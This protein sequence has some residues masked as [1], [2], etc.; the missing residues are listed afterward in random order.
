[1][2]SLIENKFQDQDKLV[3][4]RLRAA[5]A[6]CPKMWRSWKRPVSFWAPGRQDWSYACA[7]GHAHARIVEHGGCAH[8]VPLPAGAHT[9]Q[10]H[11]LLAQGPLLLRSSHCHAAQ[12]YPVLSS[13]HCYDTGSEGS[14]ARLAYV[15]LPLNEHIPTTRF[16]RILKA[17]EQLPE[18]PPRAH[19]L[20]SSPLLPERGSFSITNTVINY[21]PYKHTFAYTSASPPG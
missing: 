20:P 13:R 6:L 16:K 2:V 19:P 5:L 4:Y 1:M 21:H 3:G 10:K 12:S 17:E 7:S 15:H 14:L 11:L 18:W 9:L 8:L